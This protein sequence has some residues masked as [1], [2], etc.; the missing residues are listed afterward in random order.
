MIS[1]LTARLSTNFDKYM[2]RFIDT[3]EN[4]DFPMNSITWKELQEI[5]KHIKQ[6]G[7]ILAEYPKNPTIQW[8][9]HNKQTYRFDI[10]P[11]SD[12][13]FELLCHRVNKNFDYY[14]NRFLRGEKSAGFLVG[15]MSERMWMDLNNLLSKHGII[16][17]REKGKNGQDFMV[18]RHK[19][20]VFENGTL[21]LR[22]RMFNEIKQKYPNIPD[23]NINAILEETDEH[24]IYNLLRFKLNNAYDKPTAQ[25]YQDVYKYM[26]EHTRNSIEYKADAGWLWGKY[27]GT[28]R[29]QH[30]H[31]AYHIS[32]NVAVN[33][34]ALAAL[35]DI[36]RQDR[37]RIIKKYKIPNTHAGCVTRF[38]TITIYTV[39]RDAAL[40]QRIYNALAKY[41][42][43]NEGLI[44]Q[45]IGRGM[46]IAPETTT[47]YGRSLG[48][49]VADN[50][51]NWFAQIKEIKK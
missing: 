46:V 8:L 16:M 33:V 45:E 40:E 38:D 26:G 5:N 44:G 15:C 27:A 39:A 10:A 50:I 51:A 32:L 6:Y 25:D 43:S 48:Q 31:S 37:G 11:G 9:L 47:K 12:G 29:P 3:G 20:Q 21:S 4:V 36:L 14:L 1:E 19:K 22:Q 2:W 28:D 49:H 24:R 42:R 30:G 17:H 41:V 23:I 18:F 7:I 35:D 13:Y 34:N